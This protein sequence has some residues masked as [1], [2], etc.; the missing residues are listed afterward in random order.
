MSHPPRQGGGMTGLPVRAVPFREAEIDLERLA[1]N[2]A[3]VR[4]GLGEP[5]LVDVGADAWGH[6][7]AVVVPA[8]VESGID[9]FVVAR[10]DDAVQLRA[11][12]PDALIITTQHASDEGFDRAVSLKITPAVR[13]RSEYHR[14]V[15]AGVRAL[16]LVA[17]GGSGIPGFDDTELSIM[18]ADA[19]RLGITVLPAVAPIGAELFGVSEGDDVDALPPVMRLW[20][21]VTATKRAGI[22]EGVSYGYTYRTASETTLALV[23]LGYGDGLSRAASNTATAAVDGATH[24]IAGRVAMDAFMLDLGD[25]AAPSLGTEATVLGDASRGEP[26]A[27]QHARTLD[28]HSAEIT[29]RLSARVHRYAKGEPA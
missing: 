14:S 29:T 11:L 24:T 1:Q 4:E 3:T 12:A 9:A 10:V 28:T 7:L 15:A 22:D 2:V 27:V 19:A 5:L 21:P 16:V 26:T 23:P 25:V 8:L 17:D 20:A 6:G 18:I 13:S